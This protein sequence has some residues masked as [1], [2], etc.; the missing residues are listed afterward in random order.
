MSHVPQRRPAPRPVHPVA[1]PATPAALPENGL[2]NWFKPESDLSD[3]L[4]LSGA[5]GAAVAQLARE[6][7][8]TD[9]FLRAGLDPS[10]RILFSGP[11]GTG[12]TLAARW[13]GWT[14][15]LPVAVVDVSAI[16]GSHLG[17]T[18]G[19]LG[20]V[21][22]ILGNVPSVLFFDEVDAMCAERS[23]VRGRGAGG[24]ELARATTV[25]LQQI[26]WLRPSRVVVAATNF[27]DDLDSALRRRLTTDIVFELP[28]RDA[29]ARMLSRWFSRAPMG[30]ELVTELLDATE[31]LS[32]ADLRSRA[33]ARARAA[34]LERLPR[35]APRVIAVPPGPSAT[36]LLL[37]GVSP[38]E[39]CAELARDLLQ[40]LNSM[41]SK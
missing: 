3:D 26:D 27:R 7:H 25:F 5:T 14:L 29:R 28:D 24:E 37:P 12:K 34:L 4:V 9:D 16:V 2:I 20:E 30:D 33:M 8:H 1:V 11:S 38:A 21:F 10:T 15:S 19:A 17:E 32:G 36:P 35:P 23:G 41:D 39:R 6:L 18:S 22:K 13:L 31:G 40:T